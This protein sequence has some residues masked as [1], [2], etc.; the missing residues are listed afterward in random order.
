MTPPLGGEE[1]VLLSPVSESQTWRR[2]EAR[3][4][5]P[6]ARPEAHTRAVLVEA[7]RDERADLRRPAARRAPA[8]LRLQA[9]AERRARLLG[10]PEGRA[11]RPRAAR[12]R[13]P[14]RGPPA[15]LRD[16]RRR[17][18]EGELRRGQR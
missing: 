6:Q 17:D 15:R 13:R 10:G 11:A 4:V 8:P 2:G 1:Y 16:L 18:P 12:A 7:A 5:Q 14:R 9:R 3:R